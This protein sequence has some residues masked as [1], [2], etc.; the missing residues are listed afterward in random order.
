MRTCIVCIGIS[1][2]PSSGL[3]DGESPL[4]HASDSANSISK[5]LS[6]HFKKPEIYLLVDQCASREKLIELLELLSTGPEIENFIFYFAG[7]GRKKSILLHQGGQ[8]SEYAANSLA[9][10]ID[11]VQANHN[12]VII[13]SCHSGTVARTIS[14]AMSTNCIA[15]SSTS[16]LDKAWEDEKLKRTVFASV[17]E[18]ELSKPANLSSQPQ[19]E[20]LFIAINKKVAAASYDLKKGSRQEPEIFVKKQKVYTPSTW[21]TIKKRLWS[22]AFAS[23]IIIIVSTIILMKSTHRLG[24]EHST[25]NIT[26]KSGPKYLSFL[27]NIGYFTN[28][29]NTRFKL[30]HIVDEELSKNIAEENLWWLKSRLSKRKLPEWLE[31]ILSGLNKEYRVTKEILLGVYQHDIDH[32]E[33]HMSFF[34][35]EAT[36]NI[37]GNEFYNDEFIQRLF[38]NS[39]SRSFSDIK[40]GDDRNDVF[41]DVRFNENFVNIFNDEQFLFAGFAKL[42]SS[43]DY[44][45]IIN[46]IKVNANRGI[47]FGR[48]SNGDF[49]GNNEAEN[50]FLLAKSIK[51]RGLMLMTDNFDSNILE[52]MSVSKNID[53]RCA[54]QALIWLAYL[55]SETNFNLEESLW[56]SYEEEEHLK[57][58]RDRMNYEL[59]KLIEA[60]DISLKD[61][62]QSFSKI[63]NE[64]IDPLFGISSLVYFEK[65]TDT[66]K[67]VRQW[68][69]LT[70]KYLD[71]LT[72]IPTGGN[73]YLRHQSA[74]FRY[75]DR[76]KYQTIFSLLTQKGSLP[77]HVRKELF[78]KLKSYR[79]E[80]IRPT[81]IDRCA[82]SAQIQHNAFHFIK[83]LAI[84]AIYLTTEEYETLFNLYLLY[85]KKIRNPY[86]RTQCVVES[87]DQITPEI[88]DKHILNM[89]Q[90]LGLLS[91]GGDLKATYKSKIMSWDKEDF[92]KEIDFSKQ[93]L[94]SYQPVHA[95]GIRIVAAARLG[96]SETL[97]PPAKEVIKSYLINYYFGR[98]SKHPNPSLAIDDIDNNLSLLRISLARNYYDSTPQ[99]NLLDEI[100][101]RFKDSINSPENL[102]IEEHIATTWL[103]TLPPKTQ[104]DFVKEIRKK[105]SNEENVNL[106]MS[107]AQLLILS[108]NAPV[109]YYSNEAKL[110]R[111][112]DLR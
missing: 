80:N 25:G 107:L 54:D 86:P 69:K 82:W 40:C 103:S 70:K 105:H 27:N 34:N 36:I 78:D 97:S 83:L 42:S 38:A 48:F 51:Y 37:F 75:I 72:L 77:Q 6:A 23:T 43:F 45:E 17:L 47:H 50:L 96:L 110:L 3:I 108:K 32:D 71:S 87:S 56:I 109:I 2:Y 1:E 46:Q 106:K 11:K 7:H 44:G 18:N 59:R 91:I 53:K 41:S 30:T 90:I 29:S 15:V 16:S 52:S 74:N 62:I 61:R 64:I 94:R 66:K 12:I 99:E 58:E 10:N 13:D 111:L 4:K 95:R 98:T 93:L 35:I 9:N 31:A 85:D 89:D 57:V 49:L 76:R 60:G 21:L 104:N 101:G 79:L 28:N 65:L 55:D 92:G 63:P 81:K 73:P 33:K 39:V 88:S 68:K 67:N 102:I 112:I 84:Q 24:I 100:L 5:K 26:L 22:I 14:E 8:S 19:L 20:G